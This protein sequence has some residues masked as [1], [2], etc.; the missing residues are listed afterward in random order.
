VQEWFEARRA[1]P[2]YTALFDPR[3]TDFYGWVIPKGDRLVVGAAVAPGP[4]AL[5]GFG[6][7]SVALGALVAGFVQVDTSTSPGARPPR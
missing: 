3:V 1:E 4:L 5:A 7:V 2:C 6:L